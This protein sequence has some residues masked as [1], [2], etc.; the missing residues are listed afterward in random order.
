MGFGV[1]RIAPF[2]SSLGF[3]AFFCA[4]LAV[5][6]AL[7][8]G[9][10]DD[11]KPPT[12]EGGSSKAAGGSID[13]AAGVRID[14]QRRVVEVDAKVC[15]TRGPLELLLCSPN[16]REHESVFVTTARPLHV[17]EALGLIGLTPG[18]PVHYDE[19]NER[20]VPPSGE[21]L[22]I[23]VE[24]EGS[25]SRPVSHF[26]KPTG[27]EAGIISP[28]W[29]FAGSKRFEGGR[30]GADP[31][32][33][34]IAV[35]DFETAIVAPSSLHSDSN[36]ALWLEADPNAIPKIGTDCIVRFAPIE[37]ADEPLRLRVTASG[38][39][40]RNGKEVSAD[41]V[42]RLLRAGRSGA[43]SARHVVLEPAAGVKE[44]Q[45]EV[46]AAKL[47]AA[48]VPRDRVSVAPGEVRPETPPSDE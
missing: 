26:V 9:A 28:T 18:K 20:W 6:A 32:G 3:G 17:Y 38:G 43:G 27:G 15:L 39:L 13:Y 25:P 1:I 24:C 2:R 36:E 14:W 7:A 23:T 40:E 42:A 41:E 8:D 12:S 30:F 21:E 33:T 35:V 4:S 10:G 44:Q 5:S 16:T 37:R 11:G 48:G 34:I 47:V 31:E 22:R 19:K 46:A 29:V 45:V